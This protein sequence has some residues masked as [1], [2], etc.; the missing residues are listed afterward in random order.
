VISSVEQDP[1]LR[2]ELLLE[3]K[4]FADEDE[5]YQALQRLVVVGFP[6][7]K[8]K[9]CKN[10]AKY[11]SVRF[12]LSLDVDGF[13]V[14]GDRLVVPKGLR[15]TY[16]QRL[17]AMH[18]G[19]D[20]MLSR[21]RK[22][23]WWPFLTSDVKNMADS[24]LLCQEH[25]ASNPKEGFVHHEQ[26]I[27]LFQF[28]HMDLASY[29][30]CQFLICVDQYSGFPHIFQCGKTAT[31]KQVVDHV[32]SLISWFSILVTIYTDGGPQFFEDGEFDKFCKGWGIQLVKSSPKDKK[33]ADIR[34]SPTSSS[35]RKK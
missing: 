16:L 2:D 18:Q 11:W 29:E 4:K 30:G 1:P 7:S 32:Q 9:L 12:E 22:S 17:L 14:R 28:V 8:D 26:P 10:L 21:A 34:N 15:K 33:L 13:V 6:S 5:E 24:C 35:T 3:L 23:I 27:F 25:K 20:K 31:A 19:A